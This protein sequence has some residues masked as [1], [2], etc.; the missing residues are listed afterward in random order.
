MVSHHLCPVTLAAS[1][2]QVLATFTERGLHMA[3]TTS[4]LGSLE[5]RR[6]STCQ[7]PCQQ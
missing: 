1:K 7:A 5:V 2:P 4:S 6:G 3:V